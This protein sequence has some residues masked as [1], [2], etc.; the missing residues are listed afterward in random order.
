MPHTAVF[1][2]LIA[3]I[4]LSFYYK[5]FSVK[6]IVITIAIFLLVNANWLA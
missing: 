4:T 3:I 1:V 5:K 2:L 6:N